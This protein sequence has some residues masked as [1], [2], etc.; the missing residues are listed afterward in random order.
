M[1]IGRAEIAKLHARIKTLE[2]ANDLYRKQIE[3]LEK[4]NQ[5]LIASLM[6]QSLDFPNSNVKEVNAEDPNDVFYM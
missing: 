1:I 2:K 4:E 3:S 6:P 5:M